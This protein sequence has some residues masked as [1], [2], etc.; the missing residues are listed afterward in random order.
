VAT[1]VLTVAQAAAQV[2]WSKYSTIQ[3]YQ[4]AKFDFMSVRAAWQ[5]EKTIFNNQDNKVNLV[6]L[7]I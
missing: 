3:L 6:S 7:A 1:V 2:G 5:Q 4:V